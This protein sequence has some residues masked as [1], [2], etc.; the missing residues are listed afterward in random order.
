[1]FNVQKYQDFI[2]TIQ[3]EQKALFLCSYLIDHTQIIVI[4]R[5]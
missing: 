5:V 1:M 2:L 4:E 3:I